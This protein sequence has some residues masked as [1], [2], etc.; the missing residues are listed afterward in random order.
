MGISLKPFGYG[1]DGL[2]LGVLSLY[3]L[4]RWVL[5][6]V[7]VSSFLGGQFND[8]LLIPAALPL[9]L[10]VQ[11]GLRIRKHDLPPS[12]GE[13]GLHFLVWSIVCEGIGPWWFHRGTSDLLDVIAYAMGATA[14]GFWWHQPALGGGS[15]N[16]EV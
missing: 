4:N 10:W 9:V 2:C 12:W 8:V 13:I 1:R 16:E 14:A 7:V 5:K 15:G 3:A 11:R 6:L